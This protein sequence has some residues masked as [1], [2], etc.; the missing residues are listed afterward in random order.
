MARE[1]KA[2]GIVHQPAKDAHYHDTGQD[3]H[4]RQ[5]LHLIGKKLDFLG[6]YQ[7]VKRIQQCG[8]HDYGDEVDQIIPGLSLGVSEGQLR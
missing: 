6:K 1:H 4:Q 5:H 7:S 2:G 3:D 8:R